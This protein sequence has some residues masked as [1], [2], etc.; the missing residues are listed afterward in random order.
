MYKLRTAKE[1]FEEELSGEPLH[2]DVVIEAIQIAQ[3]EMY[4]Y[5]HKIF[6][7]NITLLSYIKDELQLKSIK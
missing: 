6:K 3:K 1:I 2:Q 4:D 5:V 7:D